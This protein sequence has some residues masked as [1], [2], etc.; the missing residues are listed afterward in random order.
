MSNIHRNAALPR[1]A[2]DGL[3]APPT[4]LSPRILSFEIS[5]HPSRTTSSMVAPRVYAS[6][7]SSRFLQTPTVSPPSISSPSIETAARPRRTISYAPAPGVYITPS[8][9]RHLTALSLPPLPADRRLLLWT[10]PHPH[11]AQSS[12]DALIPVE[13]QAKIFQGLFDS[14]SESTRTSYGAGLLRFTQFCDRLHISE[15]LRMPV[16]DILIS[17]FV[18]D[19]FGTCTSDCIRNW[20]HG[21]RLWHFFNCAEWHGRDPLVL[22]LLKTADK[23]GAPF[24]RPPRHPITNHHLFA[25]HQDLDLNS[26]VGAATW[27]CAL[28]A[29]WGC[30]RLGELLPSKLTFDPV[31]HVSRACDLKTS[32]VNGSKVL[33][34]HIPST[35]TSPQGIDCIH[36]STNNIFCPVTALENHLRINNLPPSTSLFAYSTSTSYSFLLKSHFLRSISTIFAAHHLNPIFGHSFRIGGTVELLAAGVPPQVIMKLGGWSFLCFL[37]YWRHLDFIV[38]AAITRSWAARRAEFARTFHLPLPT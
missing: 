11:L 6:S 13:Y 12:Y 25:L 14:L 36:T 28:V 38:P 35:K 5:P 7:P 26:P 29:F 4:D 15:N 18:A 8:S 30:R 10:T 19:A 34:F 21:L 32:Y 37:I 2:D 24:K 23:Q 20:L 17:A 3:R 9:P 31:Q 16:P 22:S 33:T 1:V 27:A